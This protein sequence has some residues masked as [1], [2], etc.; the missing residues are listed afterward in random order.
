MISATCAAIIVCNMKKTISLTSGN[1]WKV[2]LLYSLPLFGSALVQQLYSLVDLLVVGNYAEEG[3]QAVDAVGNAM[4]VINV[5]LAF[6]LGGNGGCSVIVA[7]YFGENNMKKL[8]ETVNTA[9]IAFSV[10]C[11]VLMTVGFSMARLFLVGLSVHESY[12]GDCLSYLYIY[13]GSLPFVFLYN[14]GCGICSALGDSKTPFIFLAVSSVLNVGLDFLFVLVLRMG[15][16]GA[17]WATF[18]SQAVSCIPTVFVLIRKLRSCRSE[19]K[20]K[21]FDKYIFKDLTLASVPV[22]LQNSFVSVG[23][24]FVNKRI[25]LIGE[26]ATTGFT[27]A[28]K[29]VCI[30]TMS[31]C[32]MSNGHTNFV[33]QNKAAG[34]FDRIKKGVIVELTYTMIISV[35]FLAMFVSFSQF[36]TNVFIQKDKLTQ[37]ALDYSV[38]F[39]TIVS[40]FLPVVCIK[41]V[42]DGAV[43]GSGGNLGFTVSTFTDLVLR[44]V[45]VY[46]LTDAGWGFGGVSWAWG[47]GWAVSTVIAVA[48]LLVRLH[49]VNPLTKQRKMC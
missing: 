12:F 40:C 41:I 29:L 6:A 17:A 47:I 1:V 38:Q 19:E 20:P 28:F 48:F 4:V 11:G 18:I 24:F 44:V 37:E 31:V 46:V 2:L 15:V 10:L 49:C 14:L 3:A 35:V 36:F 23:N 26:D 9:L 8:R 30:A 22:I 5:L 42:C 13:I 33:S 27:T 21:A 32:S 7:K 43:R 45:F 25:N 34:E 16:A 39:L